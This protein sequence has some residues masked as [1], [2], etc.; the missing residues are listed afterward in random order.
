MEVFAAALALA[1]VRPSWR[2]FP[3]RLP[4]LGGREVPG[5]ALLVL[6]WGAGTVLAGHGGLF[7]GFGV[8]LAAASGPDALTPEVLWYALLWGPWFLTGGFLFM[9]AGLSYLRGGPPDGRTAGVAASAL[10]ALGGLA[11]TSAPFAVTAIA[12]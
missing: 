1:L 9:A 7:V 10:G 4:L 11:V 12:S 6:A 2:S 5:W 8:G 3:R